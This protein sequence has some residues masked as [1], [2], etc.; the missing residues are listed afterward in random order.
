MKRA[1]AA[2]QAGRYEE[3]RA[4]ANELRAHGGLSYQEQSGPLYVLGT[5]LAHDAAEQWNQERRR[6]L[7]LLAARYLDEAIERGLPEARRADATFLLGQCLYLA[8]KYDAA[9]PALEEAW[10][11]NPQ[12]RARIHLLLA[13]CHYHSATPDLE[14]VV[15][16]ALAFVHHPDAETRQKEE[17]W[18]QL[19]NV[20]LRMD[21]L[22]EAQ[23]TLTHVSP[24]SALAPVAELNRIRLEIV[25]A[26]R[27][28]Q[29]IP[30][31][32]RARLAEKYQ[33]ALDDLRRLKATVPPSSEVARG[34]SYLIGVCYRQQGLRFAEAGMKREAEIRFEAA[35]EQFFRTQ[36]LFYR[37]AEGI[38]AA[39][40]EPELLQHLGRFREAGEAYERLISELEGFEP[41][42]NPWLS[43]EELRDRLRA[44]HR[45][46]LDAHEYEQAVR[47]ARQLPAVLPEPEAVRLLATSLRQW[48]EY[49]E[50]ESQDEPW[51]DAEVKQSV[52]RAKWREAAIA[53]RRL[54]ELRFATRMY[55]EDL[56]QCAYCFLKGRNYRQAVR[57]MKIYLENESRQ[58][59]ARGMLGLGEAQLALG[60][61]EDAVRTLTDLLQFFPTHPL[62]YRARV[63]AARA[64]ALQGKWE[65]AQQMLETNLVQE[66][67]TPRS[68]EWRDSLFAL[69]ELLYRRGMHHDIQSRLNGLSLLSPQERRDRT[70]HLEQAHHF[71]EQA[72]EKLAEAVRR[73]P[74][75][76]KAILARYH[77]A[78]SYRKGA[79]YLI[80]RRDT[81]TIEADRAVWRRQIKKWLEAA[82]AEYAVLEEEL[83]QRQE[84]QTLDRTQALLLRNAYFA[85]ADSL[86]DL[87][88]YR[89]AIRAYSSVSN[90][91]QNEPI[92]LEAFLQ[93][94]SCYH[95]MG[96]ADDARGTMEQAK[97]VLR[98]IPADADFLATTRYDRDRWA[99]LLE[100][101]SSL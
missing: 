35:L 6:T 71:F 67:L 45:R 95:R 20:Y 3:A 66:A 42:D 22:K 84:S 65:Q 5:V 14:K 85:H 29:A 32:E 9:I 18:L 48:A 19:T 79:R 87:E 16:H 94:A 41:Y 68:Q 98:R 38:V 54:S 31:S 30:K 55:T 78:E 64:L 11:L 52:A 8:G 75:D 39:L 1:L 37:Y 60:R 43:Q 10:R 61:T 51:F 47:V 82:V 90:R 12:R 33:R 34:A 91:Y 13:N 101:L 73:Y 15:E 56:W 92:A 89:D 72:T 63:V 97:V 83:N 24:K 25:A 27:E 49:L 57:R 4:I 40:E 59:R 93:I 62:S 50:G 76:P 7:Y 99:E 96:R 36:K 46:F 23:A 81:E 77:L 53:Y 58:Q 44:A 100:W 74:Q 70:R 86:F 80:D 69:G 21:K 88:R 26:D 17:T 28:A 2:L